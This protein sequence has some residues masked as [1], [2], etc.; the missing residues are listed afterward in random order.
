VASARFTLD[1]LG[2][3]PVGVVARALVGL[4]LL[5]AGALK[6]RDPSWPESARRFGLPRPAAIALPWL[7]VAIGAL[8]VA[9]Y[10]GRATALAA[11]VLLAAFTAGVALRVSRHDDV[12]CACFGA[13]STARVTGRTLARNVVL[14]ALAAA[15]ALVQ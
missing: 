11:L 13:L 9:Q 7:E 14:I 2:L 10:G 3:S 12:P 5:A 1:W 4:V 15:G 6:A 8:L